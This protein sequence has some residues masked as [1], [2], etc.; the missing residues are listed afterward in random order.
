M[1]ARTGGL[2]KAIECHLRYLSDSAVRNSARGVFYN[3]SRQLA[4]DGL[5]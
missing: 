5:S 2:V 3:I 4:Y 1:V